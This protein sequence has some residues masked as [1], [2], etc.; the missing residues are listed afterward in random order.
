MYDK[1][2]QLCTEQKISIAALCREIDIPR[3]T[4]TEL[5]K[6]RSKSLSTDTLVKIARYFGVD[7]NYFYDEF[8]NPAPEGDELSQSINSLYEK[9]RLLFDI[10]E[11][12][13]E[14]QLDSFI[15][16]LNALVDTNPD[17]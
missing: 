17:T 6:Q 14:E 13:T 4:L 7:L 16:M 9:R 3:S 12:A 8:N 2:Y 15:V 10:S 1:I 11:K 5:K